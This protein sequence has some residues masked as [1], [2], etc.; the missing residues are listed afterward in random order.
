[1]YADTNTQSIKNTVDE[2][3][4]R[5]KKQI[6]YNKENKIIPEPDKPLITTN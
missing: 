3:V 5:R 1:M 6:L 2:T 4:R